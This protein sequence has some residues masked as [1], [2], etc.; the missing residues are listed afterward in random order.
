MKN[1]MSPESNHQIDVH[2]MMGGG[3]LC[4]EEFQG[5]AFL[6]DDPS[7]ERERN[8]SSGHPP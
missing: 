6:A 8:S 4:R 7:V 2:K 5:N 3:I 1:L